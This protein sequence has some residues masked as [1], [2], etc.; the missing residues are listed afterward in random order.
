MS[1]NETPLTISGNLTAAPDLRFTGSGVA[2]ANFTVAVTPRR[3][4]KATGE[5]I[6]GTP[7]FMRVDAWRELG[8]HC[9]ETLDRGSRVIVSGQL[10]T[11]NWETE[12]GEKRSAV[13]VVADDVGCS[14]IYATASIHKAVRSNGAP[15]P[16][17]PRTGEEA[18]ERKRAAASRGKAKAEAVGDDS[19]PP[20]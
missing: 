13:K 12:N 15:A 18:T 4:D 10:V 16:V 11:E 17:D 7:T 14:L 5:W 20:F 9:A 3:F 8:E 2:V 1:R 19:E 6:D